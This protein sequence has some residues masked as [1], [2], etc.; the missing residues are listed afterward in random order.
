MNDES[1]ADPPVAQP[2]FDIHRGD[3]MLISM[4]RGI[5]SYQHERVTEGIKITL[6]MSGIIVTGELIPAWQWF[7]EQAKSTDDDDDLMRFWAEGMKSQSD[8]EDVPEPLH[9]H[10]R[11]ASFLLWPQPANVKMHWRGRLTHISG[12]AL[13]EARVESS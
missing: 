3:P 11:N 9:I 7:E 5:N 6:F 10:L 1:T 2:D 13:G 4:V 12:W 8:S